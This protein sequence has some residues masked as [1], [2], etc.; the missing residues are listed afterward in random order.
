MIKLLYISLYIFLVGCSALSSRKHYIPELKNGW[1]YPDQPTQTS[2]IGFGNNGNE[3]YKYKCGEKSI[4]IKP[5]YRNMFGVMGFLV[6]PILP[7]WSSPSDNFT[8]NFIIKYPNQK[9]KDSI[10]NI[11]FSTISNSNIKIISTSHSRIKNESVFNSYSYHSAEV[12]T[13]EVDIEK[14]NLEL[15]TN[16]TECP[17]IKVDFK[18]K[19]YWEYTFA[20]APYLIGS[21]YYVLDSL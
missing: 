4:F 14:M 18:I 8:L 3:F 15:N 13:S 11:E 2:P 16:L 9:E 1:E 10:P 6:L 20:V 12:L 21:N 7:V 5:T 19:N 17:V